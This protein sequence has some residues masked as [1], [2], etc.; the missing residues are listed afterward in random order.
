MYDIFHEW[1]SDLVVDSSGDLALS[2]GS[3]TVSQRVFRRLLTNPGDYLWSLDYG[4]GLGQFVGFP[5]NSAAIRASIRAQL[6]LETAVP[7]TPSPQVTVS[8]ADTANGY[9]L[10]TITYADPSTSVPVQLNISTG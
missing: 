9:V 1:G 2:T 4:G 3:G 8:V 10:A 5:T 7:T 6:L